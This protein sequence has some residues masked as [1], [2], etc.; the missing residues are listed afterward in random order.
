MK[1][2]SLVKRI[3]NPQNPQTLRWCESEQGSRCRLACGDLQRVSWCLQIRGTTVDSRGWGWS[4][5]LA[6]PAVPWWSHKIRVTY[7]RLFNVYVCV[8]THR[9]HMPAGALRGQKKNVGTAWNWS[10]RMSPLMWV[11]GAKPRTTGRAPSARNYWGIS[12]V[13]TE[14]DFRAYI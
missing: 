9:N 8:H 2:F 11:L 14:R 4:S 6:C 5:R 7:F 10:F 3:R 12:S 13:P 1:W